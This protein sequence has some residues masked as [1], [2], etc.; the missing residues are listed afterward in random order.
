MHPFFVPPKKY[1]KVTCQYVENVFCFS[2]RLPGWWFQPLWKKL[3][4]WDDYSQI[5]PIYGITKFMFQTTNQLLYFTIL[6][7]PW[8]T[9]SSHQRQGTRQPP[10]RSLKK[11]RPTIAR[12]RPSAGTPTR[13]C[14]GT[15]LGNSAIHQ[16]PGKKRPSLALEGPEV[17]V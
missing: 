14:I 6:K 17:V 4:S 8:I 16:P 13:S 3:V 7:P 10:R 12:S 9:Q 1:R 2:M 11:P 5:F 15:P